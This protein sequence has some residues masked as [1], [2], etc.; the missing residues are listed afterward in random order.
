MV[1]KE[2]IPD[3]FEGTQ[4]IGAIGPEVI[5]LVLDRILNC[6]LGKDQVRRGGR[7]HAWA[8]DEHDSNPLAALG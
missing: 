7:I 8:I 6:V 4:F 2:A 3:S 1:F 5:H